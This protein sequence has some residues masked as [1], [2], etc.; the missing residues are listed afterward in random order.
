MKDYELWEFPSGL[1]LVHKRITHT[2]IAHCGIIL[3]VGSRD[4]RPHEQG[5]AHFWEHMAFKGTTKR[6]AY[7]ILSRLEGVGGELNAYTTKEKVCF[8]ASV[9]ES[10]FEK[11]LELL[12]DIAFHSTFP[13]KEIEKEKSVILEEMAMYRD[14]PSDAIF[15]NFDEI[16]FPNHPLGWNIVGTTASIGSFTRQ[17]FLDFVR[18]NLHNQRIVISVVGNIAFEKARYL[19]QKYF[20]DLPH[21]S[22][23]LEREYPQQYQPQR[24]VQHR[25]TQQAHCIIGG[26]TYSLYDSKRIPFFMLNNLLGGPGMNSRLSMS[27]REKHGLVYSIESNYS[28]YTDVGA[29]TIY[30][31][32]DAAALD[33]CRHLVMKELEK[34]H[35]QPLGTLQLHRAKQQLKGQLAMAEESNHGLMLMMG[36]SILDTGRVE[37]LAEIFD[38]IEQVTAAD[39]QEIACEIFAQDQLSELVF[40]PEKSP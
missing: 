25:H 30:F 18:R 14:D 13:E 28:A 8:H 21:Y 31:A 5:I 37:S 40:L 36:K 10:H 22:A 15:D 2:K 1:R 6:K 33:K 12:A 35:R 39:L 29:F 3:D 24:I 27:L 19:V 17:H 23:Q 26:R 32:T 38:Q 34:L 20:S 16:L 7:H 11:A 4:E 9:I